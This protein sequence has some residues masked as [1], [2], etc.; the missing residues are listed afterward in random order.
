M[1][2]YYFIVLL[3]VS[4]FAATA[5]TPPQKLNYQSVVRDISGNP[6]ASGTPVSLR[7]SI[8]DL[9]IGGTV[10]F[11]ETQNTTTNQFGL[12]N[13]QI[14]SVSSLTS[15]TWGSGDK[16]LQVELQ[17]NGVGAYTS[18][19]TSQLLSV[20]YALYAGNGGGGATGATGPTGAGTAGNTGP[21]GPTGSNGATG[22]GVAGATG[23]TGT[24][25]AGATG[26][27]GSGGGATGPTGPT[28]ANG[29]TGSGGGATGPTGPT[30]LTGNNGAT[31]AGTTGP[32]GPTGTGTAGAT[33]PTGAT[34]SGG[35]LSGGTTN[36]VTKWAT[37]TTLGV[38]QIFD[39]ATNVGIGTATPSAKLSVVNAFTA[40]GNSV[41]VSSTG[42][43][44]TN[45]VYTG[46]TSVISGTNGS[47]IGLRGLANTTN[48]QYNYGVYGYAAKGLINFGVEG[49]AG[50]T[51]GVNG[52]NIGVEATADSSQNQNRAVE[53]A[54]SSTLGS[55][56]GV[57]AIADGVNANTKLNIG[58]LGKAV[59][60]AGFNLGLYALADTSFGTSI[61]VYGDATCA[62]CVQGTTNQAG[63]FIGDVD[64]AGNL[65]KTTGTFKIDHPMDPA[66]KFLIHSFVESPDMMNIYNGNITTD[67]NG[68]AVVSLPSYFQVENIDFRYQLT[69]IGT[70]AQAIVSKE[71]SNNTFSVKTDKP[72]VKVSWQVTG[73]R[74]DPYAQQHRIVPEVMKNENERGR[75]RHPEIYGLPNTMRINYVDVNKMVAGREAK[76]K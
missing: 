36:Y 43:T 58:L 39:N 45:T 61:A 34:G 18:M 25:V 33:G 19:G 31:G 41:L 71:I 2:K 51:T 9:T 68:D 59:N 63:Q 30:G 50:G 42:A 54:A 12:V 49:D 57:F 40:A 20:P 37:A 60:S 52:Y 15:V 1:K 14:G 24:G 73:V 67:G 17:V 62:T 64:V 38:S 6:L 46:L 28:G 53:A 3:F 8:H 23:P 21:T 55:N 48:A 47:Q 70:F 22:S 66:N 72:N 32:T 35:A 10:V 56:T 11:T 65:T 16:Y 69:V 27:T 13:L 5:Q 74:N 7:F 44:T 26:P 4:A 29:V 76:K 75:Y